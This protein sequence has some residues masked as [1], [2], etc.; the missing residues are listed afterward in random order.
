[1]RVNPWE[2]DMRETGVVNG[3]DVVGLAMRRANSVKAGWL[4][5]VLGCLLGGAINATFQFRAIG[6]RIERIEQKVDKLL[7]AKP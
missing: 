6:N 2:S 1:M 3:A 7:E 5:F 4:Y